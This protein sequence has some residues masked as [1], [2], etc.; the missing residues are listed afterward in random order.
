MLAI[1]RE[2]NI[3]TASNSHWTV[4]HDLSSGGCISQ[5]RFKQMNDAGMLTAPLETRLGSF[6]TASGTDIRYEVMARRD[7]AKSL[8]LTGKLLNQNGSTEFEY[9]FRYD[10]YDHGI[11]RV[12]RFFGDLSRLVPE[13]FLI[14]VWHVASGYDNFLHQQLQGKQ[15]WSVLGPE[16]QEL[17]G[18]PL[19][20]GVFAGCGAGIQF[21]TG[22]Q[23]GEWGIGPDYTGETPGKVSIS[24][25]E[26]SVAP[27][28]KISE[29]IWR[30]LRNKD[31][32]SLT[33]FI[34][35]TNYKSR[36]Y[37]PYRE[38][39]IDSQPFPTFG[40][41]RAWAKMGVNVLRIHEGGN[42]RGSTR[43]FWHDG[44]L[45]PYEGK[46]MDQMR[47]VIDTAHELGMKIIPYFMVGGVHPR[48]PAFKYHSEEWYSMGVPQEVMRFSTPGDG[49]IWE[50]HMCLASDWR[51]WLLDHVSLCLERYDFDG[52]YFDASVGEGLCFNKIHGT[53]SHGMKEG[54]LEFYRRLRYKFPDR[55]MF[56][57]QLS[58]HIN[59]MHANIADHIINL[60]ERSCIDD[61]LTLIPPPMGVR[62]QRACAS[63][64]PVPQPMLPQDGIPASPGLAFIQYKPGGEPTM[65]R[66]RARRG[67]PAFIV[68][69]MIPYLYTF[70]KDLPLGY[71][72]PQEYLDDK[73]G[74]FY[75][76]NMLKELDQFKFN[77]YL[78]PYEMAITSSSKQVH[79]A[80][81][82]GNEAWALIIANTT[83]REFNDIE[84]AL[85]SEALAIL[86][87]FNI[88]NFKLGVLTGTSHP[89]IRT[90]VAEDISSCAFKVNRI[91]PY[92][93]II[94]SNHAGERNA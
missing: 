12:Q 75:F 68:H 15:N 52:A 41:L 20:M 48:S 85:E 44:V 74:F 77:G 31:V 43:D 40:E 51:Y 2:E 8:L 29:E 63:I 93:F 26:V 24:K 19:T 78:A 13:T 42:M 80:L 33:S 89:K 18:T 14:D 47:R 56:H 60:E 37:L 66:E 82:H 54:Y 23:S 65:S 50:N 27:F 79:T 71:H 25:G 10:Y 34:A 61:P 83:D 3:I 59:V 4:F 64:G 39:V 9:Q 57:H 38:I 6:S 94:L 67:F 28:A 30:E 22:D 91:K 90:F 81:L 7:G 62:V 72:G 55:I 36:P 53:E 58:H 92:D 73:E 76:Y 86:K 5:V 32:L 84:F 1:K 11:R 45:P 17:Q 35:P 70:T 88:R 69:G 16:S 49:Q 46:Q 21:L 87:S